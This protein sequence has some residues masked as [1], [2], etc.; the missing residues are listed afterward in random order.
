MTSIA[1]PGELGYLRMRRL[2]SEFK[3]EYKPTY[4]VIH[5][6]G[7]SGK[8]SVTIIT[9]KILQALGLR[10]GI[11]VTPYVSDPRESIQ[12]DDMPIG[13]RDDVRI[14]K[15]V[16]LFVKE[17]EVAEL[18]KV[19]GFEK[20][21]LRA[22]LYFV[23]KKADVVV[24]EAGTGGLYDATNVVESD[25][26]V[27]VPVSVDHGRILG[28][29]PAQI[30]VHKAGII[31]STNKKAVLG[32]QMQEVNEVIIHAAK[33]QKVQTSILGTDYEVHEVVISEK[34]TDFAYRGYAVEGN[35][36][37]QKLHVSL[38]GAHQADNAATAITAARALLGPDYS[39]EKFVRGVKKAL[40][41]VKNPARFSIMCHDGTTL[42]VDVAHNPQKIASVAQTFSQLFPGKKAHIV[43][44]CKWVKDAQSMAQLLGHIADR[45]YLTTYTNQDNPNTDKAMT[46]DALLSA[47][48]YVDLPTEWHS[49]PV[50]A[51]RSALS[52]KPEFIIITGSFRL[53]RHILAL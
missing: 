20:L 9:A 23:H 15:E 8:G 26:S 47:F 51:F 53:V 18:G 14:K 42:I 22:L 6:A 29:S 1:Y 40:K 16:E 28:N 50:Q 44:A 33:K 48:K 13:K 24:L 10:A 17:I 35:T 11:F 49:D 12:I 45:V 4:R 3:K 41:K 36:R 39:Y 34:G 37:L 2:Y 21:V 38:I 25:V 27:I 30:A 19:T 52:K 46:K 31:K 43:F 5:V 7:T 32:R